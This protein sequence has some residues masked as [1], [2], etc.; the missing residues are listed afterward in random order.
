MTSEAHLQVDVRGRKSSRVRSHSRTLSPTSAFFAVAGLTALEYNLLG[1]LPWLQLRS[2]SCMTRGCRDNLNLMR[3]HRG[4]YLSTP[5]ACDAVP[6]RYGCVS[7]C[8]SRATESCHLQIIDDRS[9]QQAAKS[10]SQQSPQ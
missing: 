10:H 8:R 3:S 2:P 1:K 5:K 9:P 7:V 6:R 4:M